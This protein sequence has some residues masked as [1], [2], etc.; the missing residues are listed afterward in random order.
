[1]KTKTVKFLSGLF[2]LLLPGLFVAGQIQKPPVKKVNPVK[3][4]PK[5]SPAKDTLKV[6][7]NT[8]A[9]VPAGTIY[10]P[11][12]T[13]YV[14]MHTHPMSH[15]GFGG[16]IM[17]GTPDFETP[18]LPGSFYVHRD[19][20]HEPMYNTGLQAA[21]AG[22]Y[23]LALGNCNAMHGGHGLD[24]NGGNY[25]RAEVIN[26]TEKNYKLK[27][28]ALLNADHPHTS[29]YP[30]F[31]N[32]P[33]QSSVTHQQMWFTWIKR[34]YDG[35][36]RIM[37]ML[38]VNNSLLARAVDA[39]RKYSDDKYSIELQLTELRKF[40]NR[41]RDFMQIAKTPAEALSIVKANKMAVILGVETDDIGNLTINS[42]F[43]GQK[44]DNNTVKN[45]IRNLYYNYDV[46]YIFPIHVADN[47]FG[48][49]AVYDDLLALST[50]FYTNSY[51][52]VRN[53][54]GEN[55][56]FQ[57]KKQNFGTISGEALKSLDL[58]WVIN[59]QPNY[60]APG[61]GQGH[62]NA[63]GLTPLGTQAIIEMMN[64][65]MMID[66]D[67]MSQKSMESAI[68][69]SKLYG[70]GKK[71]PNGYPLNAG[72]TG[73]RGNNNGTERNLFR[74]FVDSIIKT[75]GMIGVGT[76]NSTPKKFIQAFMD[77]Y[78][79]SKQSL[80]LALGTDANGLEP[81]P[82]ATPGLNK[83]RFYSNF[84]L[85]IY[86]RPN[87]E[88]WDYTKEGVAHYGLMPEFIKDVKESP[89]GGETVEKVLKTSADR[90]IRMWER[91]EMLSKK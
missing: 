33:N 42:K 49:T 21:G 32:W 84:P 45:E 73:I 81:L 88:P 85:G 71:D 11:R 64:L 86:H 44:V 13:G 38:A 60:P 91:C 87:G 12:V 6:N 37:V 67:H 25:I 22:N 40:V 70:L 56:E 14:D 58:G 30:D 34:A 77:I 82:Q 24:N 76:A 10:I 35:G 17:Y 4:I 83:D 16:K 79:Q 8:I 31:K 59:N 18:A 5:T 7:T 66:I 9:K 43:K 55:I 50:K 69:I 52:R 53:S 26:Q 20:P 51:I 78:K 19:W 54:S 62:A 41:H 68:A 75:G 90:F 72:H 80:N 15:L 65:G 74:P 39:E 1:M 28:S 46:R 57:L 63:K 89:N 27:G 23:M 3:E 47:L 2:I 48:G 36:M 61:S 29:G